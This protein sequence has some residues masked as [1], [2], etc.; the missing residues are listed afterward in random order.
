MLKRKTTL[1]AATRPISGMSGH[2]STL[3]TVV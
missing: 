1:N 3:A 2:A